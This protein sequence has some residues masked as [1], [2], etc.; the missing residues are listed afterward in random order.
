MLKIALVAPFE[1][2]VPPKKYGGTELVVYNLTEELTK[3]GHDVTLFASGDS[4]TSAKLVKCT[5]KAIRRIRA[6]SNARV[7][8]ALT[9]GGLIKILETM[10]TEHFDIVHNHMGWPMFPLVQYISAP[11]V[12]TLHNSLKKQYPRYYEEI[13]MHNQY[14]NMPLV[15]ISKSQKRGLS[16][17]NFIGTVYNGIKVENFSFNPRPK[18]YLLFFG[19]MSPEKGP[20]QAINIARRTNSKLIMFGKI[21]SF[22]RN[23]FRKVLKPQID[24]KQIVFLGEVPSNSKQKIKLIQNARA[25]L[26]PLKW[27][28]PFGLINLESMAC[29]TPVITI[30]RGSSPELIVNGKTGYLC[31]SIKEMAEKVGQ[32]NKINRLDCRKHVEK[33][34]S[35]AKMTQGYLKIY[36]NILKQSAK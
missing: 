13:Y 34:F 18:D 1:E 21:N 24:G 20:E 16:G 12:T 2:Q 8:A 11:I 35:A 17:Y 33:N 36:E 19:R 3:L 29:G 25:T 5:P 26:S 4:N 28:E 6:S 15:S 23:Y 27:D 22:E 30:N 9:S 10:H 31:G 7:N 14:K 32:I